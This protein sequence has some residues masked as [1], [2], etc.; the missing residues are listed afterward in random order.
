MKKL[1]VGTFVAASLLSSIGAQAAIT[2]L[3]TFTGTTAVADGIAFMVGETLY[4]DFQSSTVG[5]LSPA[6]PNINPLLA[7]GYVQSASAP[8]L[9]SNPNDFAN[10]SATPGANIGDGNNFYTVPKALSGANVGERSASFSVGSNFVTLG[11]LLGS[12]DGTGNRIQFTSGGVDIAGALWSPTL[13]TR[14]NTDSAYYVLSGFGTADGFRVIS[15]DNVATEVDAIY[16]TAVPEPGEWAMMIAG[17]GVVSLIA[18]R[19]KNQA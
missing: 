7:D 14:S 19:R 12:P 10:Y 16:T 15:Y 18:R 9:Y 5:G 2:T 11:L 4:Q 1:F 6:L 8:N 17:L 3:G 13:N